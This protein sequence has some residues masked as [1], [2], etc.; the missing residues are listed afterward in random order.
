M[1]N[2]KKRIF[3][4]ICFGLIF[5]TVG[6]FLFYPGVGKNIA[7]SKTETV[8]SEEDI[9]IIVHNKAKGVYGIAMEYSLKRK[10]LGGYKVSKDPR[11]IERFGREKIYITLSR[12]DFKNTEGPGKH[13][14]GMLMEIYTKNKKTVPI[15]FLWEWKASYGKTYAFTLRGSK[16]KGFKLKSNGKKK[17]F[18]ATPW[19]KLNSDFLK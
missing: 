18:K 13:K 11:M 4:P 14:F 6:F 1:K 16:N 10:R 12:D 2:N 15:K 9:T 8:Q 3:L 17:G 5:F 19:R 7:E